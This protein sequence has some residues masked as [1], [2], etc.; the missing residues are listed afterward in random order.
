MVTA[1]RLVKAM[2]GKRVFRE[3]ARSYE[4]VIKRVRAGLPYA[5]LEAVAARFEISQ[6]KIVRLLALPPRTL[7]RR[8]KEGRLRADESDRLLRVSRI[9]ALAE[10]TLGN[11][12]RAA[13]WLSRANRRRETL[14]WPLESAGKSHR[15]CR[16]KRRSRRAGAFRPSRRRP[17]PGRPGHD[18]SRHSRSGGDLAHQGVRPA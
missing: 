13:T 4:A 2:G 1:G 16:G 10:E 17:D 11:R 6:D 8:K 15:L 5:A 18:S 7:A 12:E 14:W 9:G 3:P